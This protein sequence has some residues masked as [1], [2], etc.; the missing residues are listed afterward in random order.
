MDGIGLVQFARVAREVA[1]AAL[2]RYRSPFSTQ[3]FTQPS[4]RAIL[5]LIRFE[6][7]TSREAEVRLREHAELRIALGIE[8][9]PDDTTLS[10]CGRRTGEEVLTRFVRETITT[11]FTGCLLLFLRTARRSPWMGRD[12]RLGPS[13]PSASTRCAIAETG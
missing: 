5:C 13:G 4:L 12:S 11:S 1:E 7:W 2:P 8:R 9:V 6:D 10:L 3:T